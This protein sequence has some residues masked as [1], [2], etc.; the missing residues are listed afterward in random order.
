MSQARKPGMNHFGWETTN[1]EELVAAHDFALERGIKI[2]KTV[3]HQISRSLYVFDP[4]GHLNEW[5]ADIMADWRRVL[6]PDETDLVTTTWNVG[7]GEPKTDR[8]YHEN[9][10]IVRDDQAVFHPL[11]FTHSV[12]VARNFERMLEHYTEFGGLTDIYPGNEDV[13]FLGGSVGKLDL[14]LVRR[15]DDL[16]PGVHHISFRVESEA[17][18]ASS[19]ERLAKRG[20]VPERIVDAAHKYGI[21]L[22]DPDDMLV[23]FQVPR[24][25]AYPAAAARE[26][27]TAAIYGV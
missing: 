13:R 2:H 26:D 8:L 6:N 21:F 24:E 10:P 18:L 22:R 20:I 19:V 14:V 23:E 5:Y 11:G 3:D 1:E 4:D 9:P 15:S 25:G 17:D 7:S 16:S 27:I 12:I